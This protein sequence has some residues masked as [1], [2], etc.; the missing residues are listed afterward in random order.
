MLLALVVLCVGCS[1]LDFRQDTRLT[2]TN[3]KP[4]DTVD[5][6]LRVTWTMEEF[7]VLDAADGTSSRDRG[8]FL[9]VVDGPVLPPGEGLDWYARDD[10]LCLPDEGCPDEGYL[11]A[12]G[13]HVTSE[14][15]HTI[16]RLPDLGA[17][18][19]R[20]VHSVTI[21]LLD[22]R[23]RR[24]GESAFYVDFVVRREERTSP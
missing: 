17:D 6:P 14:T 13:V 24:A 18:G 20:D 15:S 5:L 4:F 3:P 2:F 7:E 11:E 16:E 22:G 10:D 21:V 9:V 12:R 8:R 1:G 19:R 23:D